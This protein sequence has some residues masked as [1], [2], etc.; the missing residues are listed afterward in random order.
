[1][2]DYSL[3]DADKFIYQQQPQSPNRDY[4]IKLNMSVSEFYNHRPVLQH[5]NKDLDFTQK[6]DMYKNEER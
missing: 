4:Q 5:K 2:L 3:A 1:V 6:L